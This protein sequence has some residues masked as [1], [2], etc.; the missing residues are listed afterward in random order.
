MRTG[1]KYFAGCLLSLTTLMAPHSLLAADP[2][3]PRTVA[4]RLYYFDL[5]KGLDSDNDS[6]RDEARDALAAVDKNGY[7]LMYYAIPARLVKNSYKSFLQAVG[8]T[9]I[10][11]QVGPAGGSTNVISKTGMVSLFG[12]GL[13][14]NDA[15]R[16][17]DPNVLSLRLNVDGMARFLSNQETA[18]A[19]SA[20]PA[21][22]TP[23]PL[24]NAEVWLAFNVSGTG[25]RAL[26]GLIPTGDA[27]VAPNLS[28]FTSTATGGFANVTARFAL[29]KRRDLRLPEYRE[30][31]I[32]W[33]EGND[34]T[35]QGGGREF[36]NYLKLKIQQLQQTGPSGKL[37]KDSGEM[38]QY[39]LWL[40]DTREKLK[41]APVN[42]IEWR[43]VMSQQLDV[44]LSDMR[45]IDRDFDDR[46]EELARAYVRYLE[47]R[48]D[49][50]LTTIVPET[51]SV[52]EYSYSEAPFQPRY[53]TVKF[54][55]SYNV[56]ETPSVNP[57]AVTF[58]IGMDFY[59]D[60]EPADGAAEMSRW[61]GAH[62]GAQFDRPLGSAN[63]IGQLS[64][65]AYYA[66][67]A[68]PVVIVPTGATVASGFTS[69]PAGTALSAPQGSLV[70]AHATLVIRTA[71]NGIKIPI[72]VSWAS[73]TD[74]QK[75]QEVRGHIGITFDSTPLT[76]LTGGR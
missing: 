42:E 41:E 6:K 57:G 7:A 44:L 67:L 49:P 62:F 20:D 55:H 50:K 26:E 33:L 45:K 13:D 69:A 10:D 34:E 73:R 66:Y 21:C 4:E 58:N 68:N 29:D 28:R 12:F 15:I 23:G 11:D 38:D 19:C 32:Q 60:A 76:L 54:S 39:T 59:H 65:G 1:F 70:A 36:W 5:A 74:L 8:E 16:T 53:H 9:R 14:S 75:G 56:S 24:R 22:P 3:D 37:V 61:R 72:G 52:L 63:S 48:R 47:A 40:R 35:L 2:S 43:N 17:V 31:W 27:S 46:V 64:V 71:K 18:S 51:Q 30:R 25:T